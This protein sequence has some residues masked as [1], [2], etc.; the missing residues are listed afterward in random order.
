MSPNTATARAVTM[1]VSD[2]PSV[3]AGFAEELNAILE[4]M[5]RGRQGVILGGCL[6][7]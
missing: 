7:G 6:R 1:D 3:A 2:E 5:P 4:Q